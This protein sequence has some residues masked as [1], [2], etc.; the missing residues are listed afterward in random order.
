MHE[1]SNKACVIIHGEIVVVFFTNKLGFLYDA[2]L[3][4]MQVKRGNC[5]HQTFKSFLKFV[6]MILL[7]LCII[8]SNIIKCTSSQ[9]F[10]NV[11][12][13]LFLE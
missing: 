8:N 2:I 13:S 7:R 3:L 9:K 12:A 6:V 10:E 1:Q 5:K 4:Q 11:G